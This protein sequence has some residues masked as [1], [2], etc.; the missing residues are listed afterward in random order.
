MREYRIELGDNLRDEIRWILFYRSNNP[1][2]FN[3]SSRVVLD[4]S[5]VPFIIPFCLLGLIAFIKF[6]HKKTK[7]KI[8]LSNIPTTPTIYQY[9]ERTDFFQLVANMVKIEG[10]Y[11]STIRWDRDYAPR[12][13]H[14]IIEIERNQMDSANIISQTIYELKGRYDDILGF[15]S[16]KH[17]NA[18]LFF[19]ILSE[20]TANIPKH[21]GSNG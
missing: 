17:K 4:F 2:L 19:T 7:T 13:M 3:R 18:H 11:S 10:D 1:E 16:V 15:F 20:I 21:S 5:R 6:V 12:K 8:V 14:G 9:L